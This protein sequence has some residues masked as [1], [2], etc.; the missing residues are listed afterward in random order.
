MTGFASLFW[1]RWQ[2]FR[3]RTLRKAD[4]LRV[5]LHWQAVV[6]YLYAGAVFLGGPIYYLLV[7]DLIPASIRQIGGALLGALVAIL[8]VSSLYRAIFIA[9]DRLPAPIPTADLTFVLTSPVAGRAFLADRL[10]WGALEAAGQALLLI[11]LAWVLGR[12]FLAPWSWPQALATGGLLFTIQMAVLTTGLW[13]YGLPRWVTQALRYLRMGLWGLSAALAVAG[14]YLGRRGIRID[15]LV[16]VAAVTPLPVLPSVASLIMR[17]LPITAI[18]ALVALALALLTFRPDGERLMADAFQA[19]QRRAAALT[20]TKMTQGKRGLAHT[21]LRG[22]YRPGTMA[23][24]W[25]SL[26]GYRHLPLSAWPPKLMALLVVVAA[27]AFLSLMD[28]SIG[29]GLPLLV[30]AMMAIGGAG[31]LLDGWKHE[32]KTGWSRR[33]LPVRPFHLVLGFA[34]WPALAASAAGATGVVVAGIVGNW[35]VPVMGAA[36]LLALAAGWLVAMLALSEEWLAAVSLTGEMEGRQAAKLFTSILAGAPLLLG[37]Y[38]MQP[39]AGAGTLLGLAA[40]V[41]GEAL[42]VAQYLSFRL[43]TDQR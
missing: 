22:W 16:T 38:L 42:A 3:R 4:N 15:A 17:L 9:A 35:S 13:L 18:W 36:I 20:G 32:V 14:W 5:Y 12:A 2:H 1:L 34:L 27:P 29:A 11:P 39:A 41:L 25:R 31:T 10:V 19:E 6:I 24:A 7:P 26:A 40:L 23:V 33:L 21:S 37:A 8:L 43:T 30:P 28:P